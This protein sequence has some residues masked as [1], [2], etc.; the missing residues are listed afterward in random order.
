MTFNLHYLSAKMMILLQN[1]DEKNSACDAKN[2][3]I[4]NFSAPEIV[5]RPGP[6]RTRWGAYSAPPDRPIA[7]LQGKGREGGNERGRREGGE[8]GKEKEGR[9]GK[10]EG[11]KAGPQGL[12]EMT[13]LSKCT[14]FIF[15][16]HVC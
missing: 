7:V 3:Q 14:I 9:K 8:G 6:A 11:R 16:S 13:P 2:A 1:M 4:W 10:K 15:I 5:L 12:T